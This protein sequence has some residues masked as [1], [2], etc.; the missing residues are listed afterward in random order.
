METLDGSRQKM[1]GL[2]KAG[3]TPS[4]Q[5]Q[6]TRVH[7]HCRSLACYR[8]ATGGFGSLFI[9]YPICLTDVLCRRLNGDID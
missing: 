7:S 8:V 6:N 5:N 4:N 2:D 3:D 9:I 1:T